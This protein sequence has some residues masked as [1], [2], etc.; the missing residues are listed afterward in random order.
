MKRFASSLVLLA[1]VSAMFAPLAHAA[2]ARAD[3]TA[4]HERKEGAR[5]EKMEKTDINSASREELIEVKGIDGA[6]AD[7]IIAGRPY[8]TK[9][10]LKSRKIVG[11]K[12]YRKIS[13]HIVA[14][15]AK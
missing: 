1:F 13:A 10:E 2:G 7:K 4:A 14:K 3:S 6:T 11:A 5:A 8:A 15:K 12:T 9:A